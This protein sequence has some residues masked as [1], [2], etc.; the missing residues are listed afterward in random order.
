MEEIVFYEYFI[1]LKKC[2]IGKS[3]CVGTKLRDGVYQTKFYDDTTGKYKGNSR[4]VNLDEFEQVQTFR[5][6]SFKDNTEYYHQMLLNEYALMI[7]NGRERLKKQENFLDK[8][9]KM[10]FSS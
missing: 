10:G 4:L 5:V 1:N 7:E 2:F 9:R 3:R 8:L 6:F